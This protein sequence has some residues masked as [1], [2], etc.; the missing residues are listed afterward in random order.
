MTQKVNSTKVDLK[1]DFSALADT[2]TVKRSATA[3]GPYTVVA[4]GVGLPEYFDTT[5]VSGTKYYYVVSAINKLGE[6]PNSAEATA[7]P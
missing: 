7:A 5:A 3:G 1:W 6:S 4:A 2:Y